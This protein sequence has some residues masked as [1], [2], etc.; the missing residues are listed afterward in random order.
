MEESTSRYRKHSLSLHWLNFVKLVSDY[1]VSGTVSTESKAEARGKE[2]TRWSGHT[3]GRWRPGYWG[4]ES[5]RGCS[6]SFCSKREEGRGVDVESFAGVVSRVC[7]RFYHM[8]HGFSLKW[9]LRSSSEWMG[10]RGEE[11]QRELW[12]LTCT[13][14]ESRSSSAT[15]NV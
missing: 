10:R 6:S 12:M 8:T 2:T 4:S 13:G 7:R 11:A 3:W 15:R 1:I 9:R 14:W 5:P